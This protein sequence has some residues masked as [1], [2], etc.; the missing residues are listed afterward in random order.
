MASVCAASR[1][2]GPCRITAIVDILVLRGSFAGAVAFK[3]SDRLTISG[4]GQYF[5]DSHDGGIFNIFGGSDD[6]R[7]GGQVDFT[8]VPDLLT[9]VQVHYNGGDSQDFWDARLRVE[10]TF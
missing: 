1:P 10:S 8:P 5:L 6:Y 2:L 7:V 9:R 4:G 3:V